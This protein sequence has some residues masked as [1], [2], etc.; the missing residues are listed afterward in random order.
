MKILVFY[1]TG[2]LKSPT[3]KRVLII[4]WTGNPFSIS[5]NPQPQAPRACSVSSLANG[6]EAEMSAMHE[7]TTSPSS[8]DY[9]HCQQQ[10]STPKPSVLSHN[11]RRTIGVQR[12]MFGC[13][14]STHQGSVNTVTHGLTPRF[15]PGFLRTLFLKKNSFCNF[16]IR[17]MSM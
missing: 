13:A 7:L 16:K 5:V 12:E 6:S 1:E 3:I 15:P 8:P 9:H 14:T 11:L 4:R 17:L 10:P 2:H